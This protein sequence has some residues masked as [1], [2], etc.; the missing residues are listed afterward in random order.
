LYQLKDIATDP[1]TAKRNVDPPP[2]MAPAVIMD[3]KYVALIT[4]KA[5]GKRIKPRVAEAKKVEASRYPAEPNLVCETSQREPAPS[6]DK[7]ATEMTSSR[8]GYPFSK[9]RMILVIIAVIIQP[10]NRM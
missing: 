5:C 10:P 7:T 4:M 2:T 3:I 8:K 6:K 9:S 1:I